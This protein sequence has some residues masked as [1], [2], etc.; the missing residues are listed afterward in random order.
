MLYGRDL[1]RGLID[2]LLDD[3]RDGHGGALVLSGDPGMG[4]TA[5]L[6][7]AA[8]RAGG[9]R[10]LRLTG[11][12]AEASLPFA[13]LHALLRPVLG[14]VPTLPAP[15]AAALS[16]ALGL[17]ETQGVRPFLVAA[18]VLGVLTELAEQQP[19]LCLVD[20]AQWVDGASL[21]ALLFAA[22]RI[23]AD[24][25]AM[26]YG[27]RTGEADLVGVRE[28]RLDPIPAAVAERLVSEHGALD[29]AARSRVVTLAAGNPLALVELSRELTAAGT[30]GADR[31]DIPL[32]TRLEDAFLQRARDL[33]AQGRRLLLLAAAEDAGDLRTLLDAAARL[34]LRSSTLAAAERGGLLRVDAAR[35][36]FVHPLVRSA[37]YRRATFADRQEA[38]LALAAA[39]RGDQHAERRVWHR[40][41]ATV[42]P[43]D[44][45]ACEL[46]RL[47]EKA[48]T[49]GAHAQAALALQRAGGLSAQSDERARRL[50][51]AAESWWESGRTRTAW[52]LVDDARPTPSTPLLQGRVDQLHGLF[53]ARQGVLLDGYELLLRAADRLAD[54]DPARA[55]T[56]L[57]EAV[58]AASYAGDIPRVVQAGRRADALA[59]G[60]STSAAIAHAAGIAALFG[61]EPERATPLLRDAVARG[62]DS[63]D[64]DEVLWAGVAGT[65]LM[66]VGTARRCTSR[67]VA[68]ARSVGALSTL[69]RA[70]E[71][72]GISTLSS[73]PDEAE[74]AAEEGLRRARETGQPPVAAFHLATLVAVAAVRGDEDRALRYSDEVRRMAARHGLG[75]P[76]AWAS[77]A[78][79]L[80]DLG[81]GRPEPALSR[82]EAL[83]VAGHPTFVF[84]STP[85]RVE[86]AVRA[87]HPDRARPALPLFEEWVTSSGSAWTA[88]LLARCRGLLSSGDEATSWYEQAL[89]A[90]L[91]FGPSFDTARTQLLLGEHL[92][93]ERRRVEARPHLRQAVE[94]F[95]RLGARPWAERA[96]TELRA[97]GENVRRRDEDGTPALTPQERQ[98]AAL[99]AGGASNKEAAA[100]LYLSPRTVDAHL[101]S[102]FAKLGISSRSQLRSGDLARGF[103][104]PAS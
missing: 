20:D 34:D 98:I 74:S 12:Q 33:P 49:R 83:S 15:Q 100:Q 23:G 31:E 70:L 60:A 50:L 89:S 62:Q 48:R 30:D 37:V 22:R 80:L 94:T 28:L 21:D 101:R 2:R 84:T 55:A 16:G 64:P 95:A 93:R 72:S 3:A 26:L 66:D 75:F 61:G 19:V 25:V 73:G 8:R 32:S 96:R 38:H 45:V 36:E 27:V 58:K 40:A 51:D 13:G 39:L 77:S 87:G 68:L 9:M 76:E 63:D 18:G 104:G 17:T 92:R 35:V 53:Q 41:A 99:V 44:D 54:V 82:L 5:L 52:A 85:D 4:K 78:L 7:D 43:D 24:R 102:V 67:A 103:A 91:R 47:A 86:A 81:L 42:P 11:V 6:A 56:C 10:V 65:Y 29:E 90:H 46:E 1:E 71:S 59:A 69:A 88:G 14:L 97:S 57:V 79:A